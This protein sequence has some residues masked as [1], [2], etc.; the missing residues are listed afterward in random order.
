VTAKLARALKTAMENRTLVRLKRRFESGPVKGYVL[1]MG[2]AFLMIALVSD[3][4]RLDGFE[5]FRLEDIA[6]VKPDPYAPFIETALA[7]RGERAP[8]APPIDLTS[9][10]AIVRSAGQAFPLVTLHT[11]GEDPDVC[12][13]GRV[14]EVTAEEAVLLEIGPDALWDDEVERHQ[15]GQITRVN[16]GGDYEDALALVADA[17]STGALH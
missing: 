16:F 12:W 9:I 13:I 5:I 17:P 3:R 1:A 15:L 4:I 2:P 11:E 7:K 8:D 14:V 6:D 10:G